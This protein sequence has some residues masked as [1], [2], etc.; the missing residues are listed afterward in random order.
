VEAKASNYLGK[1]K[2]K[3]KGKAVFGREGCRA[4]G[5]TN[6]GDA[7]AKANGKTGAA[8]GFQELG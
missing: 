4:A 6:F 2:G 7:K 8:A 1:G 5:A 3:G